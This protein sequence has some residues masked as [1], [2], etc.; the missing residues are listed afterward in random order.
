MAEDDV[1]SQLLKAWRDDIDS[2]P[3]PQ[4]SELLIPRQQTR[5]RAASQASVA[6]VTNATRGTDA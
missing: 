1:L 5:Q 2:V 6:R 3:F 4:F